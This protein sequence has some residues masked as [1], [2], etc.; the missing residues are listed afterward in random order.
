MEQKNSWCKKLFND[1]D[2]QCD[3]IKVCSYCSCNNSI[4]NNIESIKLLLSDNDLDIQYG[5]ESACCNRCN[6]CST[7][8][9][10][11]LLEIK[12]NI[13]IQEGFIEACINN[14]IG[15]IKYLLEINSELDIDKAFNY[16]CI[17]N[18]NENF[19]AIKYLLEIKPELDIQEKFNDACFF[20]DNIDKINFLLNIK[21]DLDIQKGFD[22]A[23]KYLLSNIDETDKYYSYSFVVNY[24]ANDNKEIIKYLLEN[25]P[26][27]NIQPY[28]DFAYINKKLSIIDFL[29][30]YNKGPN[31]NLLL[32]FIIDNKITK[33]E[34]IDCLYVSGIINKNAEN[35]CSICLDKS[36]NIQTNCNHYYCYKCIN[37]W[38]YKNKTCPTCRNTLFNCNILESHQLIKN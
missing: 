16:A 24:C 6:I 19:T 15:T 37:N 5:F 1:N 7:E 8:I 25:N 17:Y 28:L 12:P 23:C 27:L 38:Y 32:K 11:Y 30:K 21:P 33:T 3:F 26:E 9:I 29:L 20:S 13:N 36:A 14:N 2:S 4:N 34:I 31:S 22:Y 18:M 10:N 35:I